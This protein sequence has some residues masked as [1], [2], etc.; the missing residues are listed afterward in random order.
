MS[1]VRKPEHGRMG[2]A[3]PWAERWLQGAGSER[4]PQQRHQ[5]NDR[6]RAPQA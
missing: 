6:E 2:E 1:L 5:A 4:Q 3:G